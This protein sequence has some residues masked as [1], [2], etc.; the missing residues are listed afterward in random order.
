[1][2]ANFKAQYNGIKTTTN[3]NITNE[4]NNKKK[5]EHIRRDQTEEV[6]VP[7]Q[8]RQLRSTTSSNE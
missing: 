6:L 1:M 3:E 2:I 7:K 4:V 5:R 8:K